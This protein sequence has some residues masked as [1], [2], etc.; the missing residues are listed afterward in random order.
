MNTMELMDIIGTVRRHVGRR[1][2]ITQAEM[3][4][5]LQDLTAQGL[6]LRNDCMSATHDLSQTWDAQAGHP[7]STVS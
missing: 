6:D 1:Y 4:E 5:I 7:Q 3:T 2:K